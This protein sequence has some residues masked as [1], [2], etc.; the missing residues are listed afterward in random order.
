VACPSQPPEELDDACIPSRDVVRD[1]LEDRNRA[2]ATAVVNGLGNVDSLAAPVKV[3][4]KSCGEQVSNVGDD[5][6]VA[7]LDRL[8]FPEAIH[9]AAKDGGLR[10]DAVRKFTQRPV[11][12]GYVVI[13]RAI[14]PRNE[15]PQL[16]LIIDFETIG[17]IRHWPTPH[18]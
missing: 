9:A 15:I 17:I 3:G 13:L 11:F 7:G 4:N 18:T 12:A 8:I 16:L 10:S 14:K 2:F 5:P 1:L 6:V